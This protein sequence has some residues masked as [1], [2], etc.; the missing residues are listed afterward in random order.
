MIR[1]MRATLAYLFAAFF[2][3]SIAVAAHARPSVWMCPPAG[4]NGESLRSLFEDPGAWAE[5]RTR[6]DGICYADHW[7]NR[8]FSDSDLRAW[9]PLLTKWHLRLGLEVGALKPWG[10]TA[11]QAFAA[12]RPKWDR[13]I[14]DGGRIDQL[15]MDEP[16]AFSRSGLHQTMTYAADQTARFVALVRQNYP[17]IAIGDIEP[18]PSISADQLV[19]F[20]AAVQAR[21]RQWHMRGLDFVRAD[22]DWMHF[23]PGDAIG[24]EGWQGVHDLQRQFE[25]QGLS[26]SLIYWAA[27]FPSLKRAGMATQASWENGI[28]REGA[29]YAGVAGLPDEIVIES[30][31]NTPDRALPET[32]PDTFTRSVLDFTARYVPGRGAGR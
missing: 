5:T 11:D 8:Q 7:L 28:M 26:F 1:R 4:A 6:I 9:L 29:A 19:E 2:L 17:N 12:D 13:F 18:Y 10:R 20:I 27:D 25:A 23:R 32:E 14:G 24:G 30:W 22:V 3:I 21:L 16:F 31:V 15:A